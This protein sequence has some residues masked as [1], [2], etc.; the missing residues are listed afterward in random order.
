MDR[1]GKAAIPSLARHR[2]I[3][4]VATLA[5]VTLVKAMSLADASAILPFDFARLP[6]AALLGWLA[7]GEV[8]DAWTWIGAGVIFGSSLYIGRREA[9]MGRRLRLMEQP[10]VQ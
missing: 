7:F 9:R 4:P 8:S 2:K 5:H 1:L 10:G 6:F 3:G